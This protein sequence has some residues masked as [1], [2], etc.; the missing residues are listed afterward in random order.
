MPHH[1][2][3]EVYRNLL[4]SI[5]YRMLG[6][7]MEAEDI[8]QD[9]YL[10]YSQ[11]DF[12]NIK[13]HK[14]Y[15]TTI[16]TRL[17]INRLNSA[18]VQREMI[19]GNWLPE[20]IATNEQ[21]LLV[22]P[23]ERASSKDSISMAF[24]VILEKLSPPERAVFLLREIFDYEY[25]EIAQI[26]EKSEDACR[27]LFS[28]AKKHIQANRPRFDSDPEQHQAILM[29]FLQVVEGGD[30]NT[31][32]N[33]LAEDAV[34]ISDGG[35]R[36]GQATRPVYGAINVARFILSINRRSAELNL[37]YEMKSINGQTGF[38]LR[39]KGSDN[40]YYVVTFEIVQDKIKQ[41]HVVGDDNKLKRV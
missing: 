30:L 13:S 4:F 19:M 33:M 22:N 3:F 17:C 32:V 35:T 28:R 15:L 11:S 24:L 37:D 26:V 40:P 21:A 31:L 9:A 34:L 25:A 36:R 18:Q 14:Y 38:I 2:E 1:T 23:S 16:V 6:T 12:E 41:I 20:P 10:R 7:A 29:R 39:L 27:Q 8:V 5:A